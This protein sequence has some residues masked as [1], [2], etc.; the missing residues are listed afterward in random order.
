MIHAEYRNRVNGYL[1]MLSPVLEKVGRWDFSQSI[2]AE[3]ITDEFRDL[4]EGL[5]RM[6]ENLRFMVDEN[7]RRSEALKTLLDTNTE[8][9]SILDEAKVTEIVVK[10]ATDLFHADACIVYKY[11][12]EDKSL[13]P[14]TTTFTE[15]EEDV[16]S[17]TI[18]AGVGITGRVAA[19]RE[20]ICESKI[21]GEIPELPADAVKGKPISM[22][23]APMVSQGELIGVMTLTRFGDEGFVAHRDM[24]LF[25]LFALQV[26]DA[27]ANSRLFKELND[28][29]ENLETMVAQRTAELEIANKKLKEVHDSYQERVRQRLSTIAPV[30]EK[31]SLGDFG[32]NIPVHETEDEFTEL[33][34]GLNLMI[35]DLRFMFDENRRRSEEL[36]E[37][38]EDL[39][40]RG[41]ELR[42]REQLY[43]T[44][45]Q[46]AQEAITLAD[47]EENII[48]ANPALGE[49]LGHDPVELVGM[50]LLDFMPEDERDFVREQT[51]KRKKG[52]TSRYELTLINKEGAKRNVMVTAAPIYDADGNFSASMGILTD[53]SD[54]KRSEQERQALL[55]TT[56][57][58]AATLD[59]AE[60]SD[61]IARS[62]TDLI[63]ADRCTIYK[64]DSE[65]EILVPH[66]T[67]AKGADKKRVLSYSIPLGQGVTGKTASL[68]KPILANNVHKD[69]KAPRIP[70]TKERPTCLLCA[71]LVSKGEL[72]GVMSLTRLSEEEFV[73]HDRELMTLFAG[74][75]ADAMA[76]S[77]LLSQ[78]RELTTNLEEMVAVR[79]AELEESNRKTKAFAREL[80]EV[81]YVT[82]HDLKTPLRAISG[83]SQ[84]LAE[85]YSDKLDS[86]AKLYLNRLVDSTKR[87]EQLLDDLLN[88]SAISSSEERFEEVGMAEII[89]ESVGMVGPGEDAEI[90]YDEKKLP[91]VYC[92]RTKIVEVLYNLIS[93]S[94]KFNDKPQKRVEIT[95]RC[96]D[97]FHEFIV[98]DN[99]IGIEKRHFDRIF[100]IFQRLHR[101]EEYGG[102]GVG[103]SMVKRVIEEHNGRIWVESQVG[104]G[105][106]IHF[107]LPE[108]NQGNDVK[109]IPERSK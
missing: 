2:P 8:V 105:T 72:L 11:D 30:M 48:F 6:V 19:V 43:R 60:V 41:E 55:D 74:Q 28:L 78:L 71:P 31:V 103:L 10:R 73:E 12:A 5:N 93:N 68:R 98:K 64:F 4:F 39:Q 29:N 62:A 75:V 102:T 49:L 96:S 36:K 81:I 22:M 107:T 83:F 63:N 51:N 47:V 92:D 40:R 53:I 100:M 106:I 57:E 17:R 16:L 65:D 70:G 54:L 42:E 109:T 18:P 34:V 58:V 101:R 69:P 20:P 80:E 25:Q 27:A 99:G 61:L 104:T 66:T 89:K 52:E 9:S 45:V 85:D 95:S 37:V 79:T 97:G 32:E 7:R 15:I 46:T 77:R 44:L 88:I 86:K 56:T 33:F 91:S 1:E 90:V 59:E 108:R 87:M 35:D 24:E 67:T 84:F 21:K 3:E 14:Q 94:I 13:L 23:A 82:S 38:N 26:A 50:T 76:N